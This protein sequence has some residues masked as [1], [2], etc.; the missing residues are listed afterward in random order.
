MALPDTVQGAEASVLLLLTQAW[1]HWLKV[2][3]VGL[4][5]HPAAG[6]LKKSY[7][8]PLNPQWE[9]SSEILVKTHWDPAIRGARWG[10][11]CSG[12]PGISLTPRTQLSTY[13]CKMSERMNAFV[14]F[15]HHVQC[16][17]HVG[18]IWLIINQWNGLWNV[19]RAYS[20]LSTKFVL[21]YCNSSGVST[22]LL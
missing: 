18:D 13:C 12:H 2:C 15:S 9:R 4:S 3:R 10:P 17:R 22:L 8:C 20:S 21:S 11:S 19:P 14:T 5:L 6:K 16:I 1:L 7:H